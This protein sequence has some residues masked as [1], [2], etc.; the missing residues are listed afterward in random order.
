MDKGWRRAAFILGFIGVGVGGWIARQV[1]TQIHVANAV[2]SHTLCAGA[3]ISGVDPRQ[4]YVDAILSERGH[5]MLENYRSYII[6][7]TQRTVEVTWAGHFREVAVFRD[8]LGCV[9]IHDQRL[10]LQPDSATQGGSAKADAANIQDDLPMAVPALGIEAA[11]T[12]AFQEPSDGP[13]RRTKAI[14]ILHDGKIIGERYAAGYN[15][16]TPIMGYSVSKSIISALIGI[17]VKQGRLSLTA[18][19]PVPEWSDPSDPRHAITVDELLRM[20]SGLSLEESDSGLDPVSRMLFLEKD[21]AG[22][23]E[24]SRFKHTP[25]S[26]WEYTSGNTLILSRILR[27]AVGGSADSVRRFAQVELFEP[28]GIRSAHIDFDVTGTPVG[29]MYVYAT[30]R[31]WARF[32]KLYLDDG[33]IN[34]RQILP[35]GWVA[36]SATP[37]LNTDYG[38]G[39]WT[40]RLGHGDAADRIAA[41]LPEDSF[42]AS[43]NFGQRVLI[44]PSRD[45]VIVRLGQSHGSEQ[46]I[47]GLL[48]L[49]AAIGRFL[50]PATTTR[51]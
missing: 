26:T 30:A 42:Y 47:R 24:K 20:T 21:M 1:G 13:Y 22:F 28:L 3:F 34:G 9:V 51:R 45:L 23:A 12:D 35:P 15:A 41:G 38:A 33:S 16:E 50:Q 14:V 48:H 25:G 4:L 5:A 10:L 40:N 18:P 32:G 17:L 36:Y 46:D 11:L 37:T 43:G 31:D 6:D 2:V 27:D 7:R 29:S 8:D 39:F 44:E 19:A 49:S